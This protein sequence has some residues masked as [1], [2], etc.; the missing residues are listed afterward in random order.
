M[1]ALTPILD[2]L[3]AAARSAGAAETAFRRETA[4][5]IKVL[6]RERSHAFRRVNLLR[7]IAE[8]VARAESEEMAVAGGQ[9]ILRAK[10]GWSNDSE[11][12]SAILTRFAMVV[13]GMFATLHPR[14]EGEAEPADILALLDAFEAWYEEAHR[15]SFWSLFDQP[16]QETPVVDF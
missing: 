14:S 12:R 6:E 4:E 2:A 10:L 3:E 5:R 15:T 1:T 9:A 13:K 7:P 11:A 16:M 8:A